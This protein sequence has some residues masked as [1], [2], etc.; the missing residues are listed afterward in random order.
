VG[1]TIFFGQGAYGCVKQLSWDVNEGVFILFCGN[2]F[3]DTGNPEYNFRDFEDW[4]A[5][6]SD[7]GWLL[8]KVVT[9]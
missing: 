2:D 4:I 7:C 6:E 1:L 9:Q 5:A 3:M 8:S